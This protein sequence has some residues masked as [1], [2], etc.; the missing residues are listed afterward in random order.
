MTSWLTRR[1]SSIRL[2]VNP[3]KMVIK[4]AQRTYTYL[5]LYGYTTDL[6][7]CNRVF[8]QDVNHEYFTVMKDNQLKYLALIDESFSPLPIR[9]IPLFSEEVVGTEALVRMADVLYG[10]ENPAAV[11]Y[12]GKPQSINK[13]D[14][15][16]LLSVPLP[17]ASKDAVDLTRIGDELIVR[18][19]NQRRNFMLPH[20]L[21]ERE[22][23]DAKLEE[24]ELHVMFKLPPGKEDKN[25]RYN[26]SSKN[27]KK[28]K[29]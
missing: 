11:M 27:D 13:V 23:S 16:Y 22:V 21:L 29:A 4:E 14:G 25:G 7:I 12:S 1:T 26:K 28:Q 24:G 15:G 18:I 10:A 9:R 2:V 19:G 17:L 6:V 8:P 20:V 3:E 5:G